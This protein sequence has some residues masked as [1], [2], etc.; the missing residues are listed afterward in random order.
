MGEQVPPRSQLKYPCARGALWVRPL[1]IRPISPI[2]GAAFEGKSP[3]DL[4]T[5][6]SSD[7]LPPYF[8]DCDRS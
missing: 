1:F 7:F 6:Y 3:S 2:P 8:S 4:T 5:A